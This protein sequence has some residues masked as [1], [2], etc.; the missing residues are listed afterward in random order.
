MKYSLWF[1]FERYADPGIID[2]DFCN[3]AITYEDDKKEAYNVWTMNYFKENLQNIF[4][5]FDTEGFSVQLPDIIV[6]RLDREHITVALKRILP[7]P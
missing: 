6:Q 4:D 7:Q 2:D 3:V 5:E 1:E